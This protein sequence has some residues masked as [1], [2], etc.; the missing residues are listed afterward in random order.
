MSTEPDL[1]AE[2]RQ[3]VCRAALAAQKACLEL[4]DAAEAGDLVAAGLA[5]RRVRVALNEAAKPLQ[6]RAVQILM[7]ADIHA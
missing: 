6:H 2:E 1:K 3:T 5:H 7:A 4:F